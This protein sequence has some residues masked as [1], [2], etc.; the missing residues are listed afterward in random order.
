[1]MDKEFYS[2]LK[3]PL[4]SQHRPLLWLC[5]ASLL[6]IQPVIVTVYSWSIDGFRR[7]PIP[8][9]YH[10]EK[11][12]LLVDLNDDGIEE[13]ALLEDGHAFLRQGAENLWGS[14]VTW[15]VLDIQISDMNRDGRKE[16]VLLVHRPYEP[17]PIDRYMPNPG[18][19]S[20]FKDKRGY[21][22]HIILIGYRKNS[23]REAWAGS[24]MAR[25]MMKILAEDID[26]DGFDELLGIEWDQNDG[27]NKPYAVSVWYWKGFNFSLMER[28]KFKFLQQVDT[29]ED[30]E[31]ALILISGWEENDEKRD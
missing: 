24:A 12:S 17:L 21:T 11:K 19:S 14:P 29:I 4:P 31:R 7:V 27:I 5:I 25:P 9:Q 8:H 16:L 28:K 22:S 1:M 26:G 23:F 15:E 2:R 20:T 3:P 18:P 30:H 6:L 13:K 10:F